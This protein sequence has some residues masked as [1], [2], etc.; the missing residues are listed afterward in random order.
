MCLWMFW[1]MTASASELWLRASASFLGYEDKQ[2]NEDKISVITNS[3]C[4]TH[5]VQIEIWFGSWGWIWVF[6]A[7][8]NEWARKTDLLLNNLFWSVVHLGRKKCRG[9]Q[10]VRLHI[11]IWYDLADNRLTVFWVCHTAITLP[12][13]LDLSVNPFELSAR[14]CR[15]HCLNGQKNV[16]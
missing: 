9:G 7:G 10:L 6:P 11:A 13:R 16:Y 8:W 1:L 2:L 3:M 14:L 15:V 4:A 5:R 12:T